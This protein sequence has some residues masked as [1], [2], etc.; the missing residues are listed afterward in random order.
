MSK[1]N[2]V[3]AHG[4]FGKGE[5]N[6]LSALSNQVDSL[7]P[8]ADLFGPKAKRIEIERKSMLMEKEHELSSLSGKL[9]EW[10]SPEGQYLAQMAWLALTTKA[11]LPR[12][13]RDIEIRHIHGPIGV[14]A[15]A[16]AK[17]EKY[18]EPKLEIH[19]TACPSYLD[20]HDWEKA[21]T[22]SNPIFVY[23]HI[24]WGK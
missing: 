4:P 20:G 2:G 10:I 5:F 24:D 13:A 17:S 18:Q 21:S 1:E 6:V 8:K 11:S 7:K 3:G 16:M 9:P 22:T 19:L 15:S 14:L 12:S 23:Q